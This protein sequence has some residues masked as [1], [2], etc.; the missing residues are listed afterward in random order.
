MTKQAAR[1]GDP[2][3][4]HIA[5]LTNAYPKISHSFIRREITALEQLGVEVTRLSM[6]PTHEP[7]PDPADAAELDRTI[8]LVDGPASILRLLGASAIAAITH[9]IRF[10]RALRTAVAMARVGGPGLVR[11]LAY[12]SQACR[13]A[14]IIRAR[15]ICHVHAHFGTNPAAVARL[16]RLL[17]GTP[18]S[19]TVHGPDEF[20]APRQLSLA[21]KIAD[22]SFIAAVS[23]FG[24]SQLMRWSRL[25]DWPRIGLVRCGLDANFLETRPAPFDDS[26]RLVCVA[27]LSAQKGLPLLIEAAA[28]LATQG[29]KFELRLVGDGELRTE[30]E[31]EISA[32]GLH[33]DACLPCLSCRQRGSLRG[34]LRRPPRQAQ[35]DRIDGP[36][37]CRSRASAD[38]RA[39]PR[40]RSPRPWSADQG[41]D[42]GS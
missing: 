6:R 18:Y 28:L 27:R 36:G 4:L 26:R 12:L 11:H 23:S 37:L 20:D 22:A 39:P 40:S 42:R 5:Y 13:V 30:L 41:R 35:A 24:R 8:V 25:P 33:A 2:K 9:H 38:A 34:A 14:D 3:R 17:S 15:R 10:L 29:R 32:R 1:H 16:V 21:E 7:L 31:G 19:L